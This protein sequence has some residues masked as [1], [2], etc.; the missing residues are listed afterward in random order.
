[1]AL[2]GETNEIK[3]S[4]NGPSYGGGNGGGSLAKR[5]QMTAAE[6]MDVQITTPENNYHV[7]PIL[8]IP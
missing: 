2:A 5:K 1:M 4:F 8:P 7:K 6:Q 3:E